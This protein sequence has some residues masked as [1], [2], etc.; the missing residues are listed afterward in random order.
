[1]DGRLGRS[2]KILYHPSTSLRAGRGHRG[3]QGR[4]TSGQAGG[5]FINIFGFGRLPFLHDDGLTGS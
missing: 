3:T 4:T 1:M 5:R 2:F